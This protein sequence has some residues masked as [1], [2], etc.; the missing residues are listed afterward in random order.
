MTPSPPMAAQAQPFSESM[1]D[2]A[3]LHQNLAQFVPT[4]AQAETLMIAA[5]AWAEAGVVQAQAEGRGMDIDAMWDLIDAKTDA[6]EQK[7]PAY[8]GTQDFR[9]WSD[10]CRSFALHMGVETGL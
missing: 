7:S 10:Y 4:D 8:F 3:A 2:C 5:R 9:D 6:A 1:A